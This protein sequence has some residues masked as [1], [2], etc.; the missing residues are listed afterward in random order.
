MKRYPLATLAMALFISGLNSIAGATPLNN[1][2]AEAAILNS[3]FI[4]PV[5]DSSTATDGK[6]LQFDSRA[7]AFV[8]V[9]ASNQGSSQIQGL[10]LGP[11]GYIYGSYF[12]SISNNDGRVLRINP[13]G[14]VTETFVSPG[15]GNLRFPLGLTFGPDSNLYVANNLGNVIRYNGTTG[16]FIDVFATGLLVP[17]DVVFGPDGDLYVSNGVGDS[18]SRFNGQTGTFSGFFV[19]P[20]AFGLDAPIGMAFGPSQDLYVASFPSNTTF[21]FRAGSGDLISTFDLPLQDGIA[22]LLDLAFG[23]DKSLYASVRS[24]GTKIYRIDPDSGMIIDEFASLPSP[25]AFN[26]GMFFVDQACSELGSVE[27]GA[28]GCFA[29][30]TVP[31][32]TTIVLLGVGLLAIPATFKRKQ[33]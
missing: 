2:D 25:L 20:G 17:Q 29:P 6:I 13:I 26:T 33:A 8:K 18:I 21:R 19:A 23:P 22:T 32:P 3:A 15:S 10:T 11:D 7:G 24:S 31:E 27:G 14:T 28:S 5:N 12:N 16:E 9:V 1:G 30:S 4:V